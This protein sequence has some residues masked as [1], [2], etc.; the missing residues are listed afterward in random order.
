METRLGDCREVSPKG[1][2][3][4][5]VMGYLQETHVFLPTALDALA[6]EGG[7]IH[8]HEACPA[9]YLPDRPRDR[10]EEAAEKAGRLLDEARVRKVKSYAPGVWHVV[11]DAIV[12]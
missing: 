4:R 11:V 10:L 12:K 5:I 9:E 8:Y 7:I 1:W 6:R 3:H 2:A